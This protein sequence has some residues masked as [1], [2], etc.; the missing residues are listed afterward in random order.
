MRFVYPTRPGER[1]W[2]LIT[3]VPVHV[4][5]LVPVKPG[6]QVHCVCEIV[7]LVAVV[8]LPG[9]A[10][11]TLNPAAVLYVPSAHAVQLPAPPAVHDAHELWHGR[12]REL[13]SSWAR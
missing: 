4:P 9:Q 12:Q 3:S 8:A 5:P 10:V 2:A 6:R 13:F 11:H 7:P 1:S